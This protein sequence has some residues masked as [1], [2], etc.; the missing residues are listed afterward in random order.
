MASSILERY[1]SGERREAWDYLVSLGPLVRATPNLQDAIAVAQETMKRARHNVESIIV[2]L[3]KLGYTFTQADPAVSSLMRFAASSTSPYERPGYE[4]RN[5]YERSMAD[6][7]KFARVAAGELLRQQEEGRRNL[8]NGALM[9]P[10]VFLPPSKTVAD[11]IEFYEDEF[12][13]PL[14]ISLCQWFRQVGSVSLMGHH[15]ALSPLRASVL[16]DPL[17]I[18][19][20]EWRPRATGVII[21]KTCQTSWHSPPTRGTRRMPA[22]ATGPTA[23]LFQTLLPTACF[24]GQ[25][26]I[27][28]LSSTCVACSITAGSRAGNSRMPVRKRKSIFSR[29]GCSH[30]NRDQSVVSSHG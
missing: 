28:P 13:G 2:K 18:F 27:P 1:R 5:A 21:R 19:R 15:E 11:E 30:S 16:A 8:R 25:V 26:R 22:A 9:N 4:P 17:V 23:W 3:E 14:P 29:K 24:P 10:D 12:G 6:S 20:C 7:A